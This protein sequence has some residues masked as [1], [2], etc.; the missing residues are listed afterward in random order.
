MVGCV[1][2]CSRATAEKLFSS[3]ARTKL[4]I[5]AIRSIVHLFQNGIYHILFCL[6]LKEIEIDED[7]L[8]NR[9]YL[10]NED[11]KSQIPQSSVRSPGPS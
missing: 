4:C 2:C 5:Q 11:V 9:S 10:K 6:L 8:I 1:V 7:S 3:I